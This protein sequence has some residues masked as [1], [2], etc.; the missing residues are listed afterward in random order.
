ML[1][2]ITGWNERYRQQQN[3]TLPYERLSLPSRKGKITRG[4]GKQRPYAITSSPSWVGCSGSREGRLRSEGDE[5][6]LGLLK[7]T[8]SKKSANL[9]A[10]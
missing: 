2:R 5:A 6:G 1:V 3:L 7:Q 10:H 8:K 4:R 9:W